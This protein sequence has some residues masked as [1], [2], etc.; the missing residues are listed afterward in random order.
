MWKSYGHNLVSLKL[1]SPLSF[2]A[3]PL[4]SPTQNKNYPLYTYFWIQHLFKKNYHTLQILKLFVP[5]YGGLAYNVNKA[6][7]KKGRGGWGGGCGNKLTLYIVKIF[8]CVKTKSN[9]MLNEGKYRNKLAVKYHFMVFYLN[10][11]K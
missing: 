7:Q 4:I 6:K 3:Q 5:S 2:S 8:L 11:S 9:W 10:N 1:N